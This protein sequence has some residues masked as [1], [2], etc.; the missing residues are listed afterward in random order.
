M[1][2]QVSATKQSGQR[3]IQGPSMSVFDRLTEGA[4]HGSTGETRPILVLPQHG[5][6]NS[7]EERVAVRYLRFDLKQ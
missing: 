3:I 5:G 6:F 7:Q 1:V 2:V 4:L